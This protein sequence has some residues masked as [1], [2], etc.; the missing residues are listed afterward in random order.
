MTGGFVEPFC[1][2]NSQRQELTALIGDHAEPFIASAAKFV[3]LYR[4]IRADAQSGQ[5]HEELRNWLAN[6]ER[7]AL[8][9]A[10]MLGNLSD[11]A[12]NIL[13]N[14]YLMATAYRYSTP[15][16]GIHADARTE[17][18][19]LAAAARWAIDHVPSSRGAPARGAEHRLLAQLA[20]S[21][22]DH[23]GR[24]PARRRGGHFDRVATLV[25]RAA[26]YTSQSCAKL[27]PEAF[28]IRPSL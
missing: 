21:Y 1:F 26:G 28:R 12:E 23:T 16:V 22:Q 15:R 11:D 6:V 2:S 19:R 3:E 13:D 27:L 9:L 25:L 7:S 18:E 4:S 17:I 8:A 20:K 5:S 14:G 24:V 10:A